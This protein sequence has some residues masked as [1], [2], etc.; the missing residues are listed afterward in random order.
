MAKKAN[1]KQESEIHSILSEIDNFKSNLQMRNLC[2]L[3]TSIVQYGKVYGTEYVIDVYKMLKEE[4]S[5]KKALA[6]LMKM[7]EFA[8]FSS[9][10]L[11]R[12]SSLLSAGTKSDESVDVS[13][14]SDFSYQRLL[15]L[16]SNNLVD[17]GHL[18]K[19][20]DALTDEERGIAADQ[21]TTS[22]ALLYRMTNAGTIEHGNCSS[23]NVLVEKLNAVG[24]RALANKVYIKIQAISSGEGFDCDTSSK[25]VEFHAN[26]MTL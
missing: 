11:V 20:V 6:I 12:L 23:L 5:Y 8:G 25:E 14:T 2:I 10:R 3:A 16:V 9:G 18:K 22:H 15:V 13:L 17:E 24:L 19:V 4:Y 7:M 26:G 21:V 1:N